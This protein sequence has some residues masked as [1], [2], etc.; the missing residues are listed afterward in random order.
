MAIKLR[1]D[2]RERDR[3]VLAYAK[4]HVAGTAELVAM[5]ARLTVRVG[6]TGGVKSGI[7]VTP[8]AANRRGVKYLVEATNA[9]SVLEHQGAKRHVIVPRRRGGMLRF[10]W[11]KVGE[12]V[13][14]PKVNHPGMKGTKFLVKPLEQVGKKRGFTV[15]TV[16]GYIPVR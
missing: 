16:Q 4:Q 13:I 6:K 12:D 2:A 7:T 3:I 8:K 10:Y 9:H 11:E 14:F 5:G 15:T 1:I